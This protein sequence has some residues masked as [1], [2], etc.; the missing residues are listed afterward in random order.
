[1]LKENSSCAPFVCFL[2]VACPFVTET[3]VVIER[4]KERDEGRKEGDFV[5]WVVL[6][7]CKKMGLEVKKRIK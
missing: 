6:S 4:K 1:M 2:L 5:V 7:Y 3:K